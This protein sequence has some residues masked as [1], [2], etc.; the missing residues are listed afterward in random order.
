M[1]PFERQ[2]IIHGLIIEIVKRSLKMPVS[3][4]GE[5]IALN[6]A[7]ERNKAGKARLLGNRRFLIFY[8]FAYSF[9]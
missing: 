6:A 7:V 1:L 4:S 2:Q 5:N 9:T 3:V 8:V